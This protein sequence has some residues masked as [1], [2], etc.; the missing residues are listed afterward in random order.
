[1]KRIAVGRYALAALFIVFLLAGCGEKEPEEVQKPAAEVKETQEQPSEP[2]ANRPPVIQAAQIRPDSPTVQGPLSLSV[3]ASDP[4]GDTITYRYQWIIN[5]A[6]D[7]EG[8]EETLPASLFKKGDEVSCI[9][10]PMDNELEG[11]AFETEPV[12]IANSPPKVDN[13]RFEPERVTAEGE[14]QVSI[15]ASDPDLDEISVQYE[16][17][18]NDQRVENESPVLQ[19]GDL[20]KKDTIFVRAYAEDEE[21]K[22]PWVQS[23]RI[24]I[25]NRPPRI[26]SKPP[27]Q[28]SGQESVTY[29]VK[30]EDPDGDELTVTL[31]GDLPDGMY[32]DEYEHT[33]T[34]TPSDSTTPGQYDF[35]I[36]ADDND[37]GR[38]IQT[39]SLTLKAAEEPTGQETQEAPGQEETTGQ[40]E[41]TEQTEAPSE[42]TS[43]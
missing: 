32:W 17:Y 11:D 6:R 24:L 35:E 38:Y 7:P 40:T 22:S 31:Q 43:K 39:I 42:Q 10:S 19:L 37:G 1:M 41:T 36:T 33:L 16:W 21:N 3:I 15:E 8:A 27:N 14:L 18:V 2:V 26:V 29:E 25:Q 5:G 28:W 23:R 34:W 9:I 13:I 30:A 4:D 20:K 12:V